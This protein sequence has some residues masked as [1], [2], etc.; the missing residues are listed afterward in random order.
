MF[1]EIGVYKYPISKREKE[2]IGKKNYISSEE[3]RKKTLQLSKEKDDVNLKPSILKKVKFY[4]YLLDMK[5][6]SHKEYIQKLNAI[7]LQ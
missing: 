6:I 2:R 3:K 7:E 1:Q 4:K 5:L